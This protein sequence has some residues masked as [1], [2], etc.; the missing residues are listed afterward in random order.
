MRPRKPAALIA[1]YRNFQHS[2][3]DLKFNER[4]RQA[5]KE[6]AKRYAG[7]D[8]GSTESAIQAAINLARMAGNQAHISQAEYRAIFEEQAKRAADLRAFVETRFHN[9]ICTAGSIFYMELVAEGMTDNTL[10]AMQADPLFINRG[11]LTELLNLI[12]TRSEAI[13]SRLE[14]G[15]TARNPAQHALARKL[16]EAARRGQIPIKPSTSKTSRLAALF[17]E[18]AQI[19][20]LEP[21]DPEKYLRGSLEGNSSDDPPP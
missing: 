16:M 11:L 21:G 18:A 5:I 8:S 10:E 3:H 13:A 17:S 6:L 1:D 9:G 2:P 14:P 4:D 7:T 19:A 20:G 12:E 15:P